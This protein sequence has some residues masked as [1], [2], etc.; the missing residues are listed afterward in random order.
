LHQ[1]AGLRGLDVRAEISK[2]NETTTQGVVTKVDRVRNQIN[3]FNLTGYTGTPT[4]VTTGDALYS[5]GSGT[6]GFTYDGNAQTTPGATQLQ[7]STN[8]TDWFTLTAPVA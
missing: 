3:G 5:C 6:S 2:S 4:T 1:A 8:G 7:V